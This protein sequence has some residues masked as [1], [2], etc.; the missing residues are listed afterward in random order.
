MTPDNASSQREPTAGPCRRRQVDHTL[1]RSILRPGPSIS[2]T[3]AEID[4][5]ERTPRHARPDLS[6]AQPVERLD[7]ARPERRPRPS[8][9]TK[10]P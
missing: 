6:V 5:R 9:T 2:P 3:S 10:S 1:F 8:A 4:A 7:Q